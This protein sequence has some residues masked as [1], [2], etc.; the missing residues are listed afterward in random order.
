MASKQFTID[1]WFYHYLL[2]ET[3]F[4]ITAK[5]FVKVLEIC[6][7]VCMKDGTPLREKFFSLDKELSAKSPAGRLVAK[8]VVK[9][10][11]SNLEKMEW[12]NEEIE[13][14]EVVTDLPRK[15]IYLIK[16]C[17]ATSDKIFITTDN[18]LKGA[19]E[20]NASTLEI[21]VHHA[22]DFMKEYLK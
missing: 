17:M 10:F 13:I 1:E 4:Q 8:T 18:K 19:L 15:D 12:I 14:P 20:K 5:F 22:D 3:K 21:K 2:D 16:L 11:I 6:D 7:R 9:G